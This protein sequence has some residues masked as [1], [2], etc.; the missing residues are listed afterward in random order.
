[1][2]VPMLIRKKITR[3]PDN[4]VVTANS[5]CNRDYSDMP[6]CSIAGGIPIKLLSTEKC[7]V[8]ESIEAVPGY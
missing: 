8:F 4:F 5:L 3:T 7:R 6:E 1:M 2:I